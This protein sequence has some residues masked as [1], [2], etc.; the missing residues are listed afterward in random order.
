VRL[1]RRAD[2]GRLPT[3]L[4]AVLALA[5]SALSVRGAEAD[6]L[7]AHATLGGA[8]ALGMPQAREFGFGGAG[9]VSLELPLG[10]AVGLEGKLGGVVLAEGAAPREPGL[11]RPGTG[12]AVLGTVGLRARPFTAVAG[13]WASAG[14]GGAQTGDRT[15]FAF[16]GALGW[17]FRVSRTSR[18]DVGPFVGFHDIVQS[19]DGLRPNDAYLLSFGVH[20]GLGVPRKVVTDRD[21]D[22]VLD[23][24]DACPDVPGLRTLDP[25]TNG[26]P[27]GDRDKD[28][29]F[30]DEDA[31]P[32]VPGVR[33]DDPA[34]NGCPRK[35]RDGDGVLDAEDACPDVPGVATKDPATNGCPRGDRDRDGVFDD[36]DACPDVPGVRTID[37]KTNGCPP[38]SDSVRVEA[39]KI[40]FDE[41]ILFDLDSPR[42]RHASFGIVK[43]LAEFILATPDILEVSIEGH[44]DATGSEAHNL[45]L[46]RERAENVRRLIIQNGVEAGRIKAEA[47]GRSRLKVQTQRAEAK[48]R[49]VEFWITRTRPGN[50]EPPP[51]SPPPSA[52]PAQ[53]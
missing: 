5:L 12:T 1:P 24:D 48:N 52:E 53:P 47:Y 39:D 10:A 18:I 30:D 16:E 40:L 21:Q 26:C 35:D 2:P 13:P 20:V 17:D 23:V 11:L 22:G 14:L 45:V 32:D 31:C 44:A 34:T 37:P 50:V 15:R 42:V 28:S 9:S 25:R 19:D 8:H 49:R 36:E 46:S 33:S 29:V 27:R 43:K 4:G 6:E 7:R 38:A 41:V 51:P 3:I